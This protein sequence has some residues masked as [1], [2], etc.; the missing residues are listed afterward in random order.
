MNGRA[1]VFDAERRQALVAIRSLGRRGIDVTAASGLR[2]NA[3]GASKYVDRRV[4]YP[5]PQDD[6]AAFVD[7]IEREVRTHDY[8]VLLPIADPTVAPVV[9]ARHRLEPYAAIPFPEADTLRI[10][11]DKKRTIEAAREAGVPHP[12][13]LAPAE[14]DVE[15]VADEIGY[16]VVV[17]PRQGA[18]RLGVSVCHTPGE[19]EAAYAN[20]PDHHHPLLLQEFV[21]NGGE[22]GVYTLYN[23]SSELKAVTVQQR[24][25]T[26]PPGGGTSTLRET[27]DD[28]GLISVTDDLLSGLGWQ[29]VAM[30]E[31][32]ID[33]RDGEPKLIEINPRLWGSLALSVGA[34]VDFPA[35]LYELATTG[36]CETVLDYR[37]GVQARR[38]LG[39]IAHVI[40]RKDRKAAL[41]EFL[42][43]ADGPRHHDVLSA[44]DPGATAA[45]FAAEIGKFA[46][47]RLFS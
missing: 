46:Q 8:D 41:R 5:R 21:P 40:A 31:F 27:V 24:I 4:R 37:S 20:T 1:L 12:K 22:R 45:Y 23:W 38:L 25:R 17:K 7:R 3:G 44:D 32:R 42:R 26:D 43:P 47:R 33:S 29:G 39:D 18:G 16:P 28:P 19:L 15:E 9:E 10:G 34:G 35:L 2:L 13:T 6:P 11:T 36:D 30:A 14:L